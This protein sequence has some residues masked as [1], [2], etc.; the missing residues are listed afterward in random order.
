[1]GLGSILF[2]VV[3]VLTLIAFIYLLV[4]TARGWGVLHSILL[5]CVFI[6]SWV[7]LVMTAGV[8]NVRVP[9]TR[10]AHKA[11]E[12][13]EQAAAEHQ[14]KLWGDLTMGS[15]AD[16]AVPMKGR[17]QRLSAER[18]RVWRGLIYN[19][20]NG[21]N[22]E[23]E[24]AAPAVDNDPLADPAAAAAPAPTAE[25]LP[26]GT[27]VYG[28]AEEQDSEGRTLPKYYLGEFVVQQTQGAQVVLASTNQLFESAKTR[29]SDGTA[30]TWTLYE[31]LP[32]DS[33]E[34]FVAEGSTPS[35]EQIFGRPDE[36]VISELFAD[37]PENIR[38]RVIKE[39]MADGTTAD[40]TTPKENLWVQLVLQRDYQDTVDSADSR[41]ATIGGY[42]NVS[43]QSTDSR[44]KIDEDDKDAAVVTLTPNGTRGKLLVLK[45]EA[46]EKID[47][48][49][50]TEARRVNVRP[51]NDYEKAFNKVYLE[52]ARLDA[53]IER[54][55]RDAEK[56]TAADQAANEMI[57]FRQA[58]KQ[59]LS[60]DL[61]NLE[62][63]LQLMTRL[64]SEEQ[65][66]LATMREKMRDMYVE[67]Q[68]AHALR[69]AAELS[70]MSN[71]P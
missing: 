1:M 52:N 34:A 7:F 51:L 41:D 56:L 25:S 43:G 44:I 48:S 64:A 16:A 27:V 21:Q 13:L 62:K 4:V 6:E 26:Q 70:M 31:L 23:L 20:Q 2:L 30:S 68:K 32:L 65:Q 28:F 46:A 37:L 12:D 55:K 14:R 33:H 29:I 60:S 24:M 15:D 10:A 47:D 69:K 19:Q 17:L 9:A 3:L 57:V 49:I 38:D 35:E 54:M 5:C 39:Y 22:F 71:A 66:K 42:F 53:Q 67:I 40:Q 61:Q 45:E 50:A 18:G 63:E 59:A 11:V 8:H 36:A 58:E